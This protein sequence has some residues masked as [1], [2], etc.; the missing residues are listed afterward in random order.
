MAS[1]RWELGLQA[2]VVVTGRGD[3]ISSLV[4]RVASENHQPVVA[5]GRRRDRQRRGR[6]VGRHRC[7]P[8]CSPDGHVESFARDVGIPLNLKAAVC[9]IFTGQVKKLDV[10]EVNGRVF[11]NNS[12]VGFYPHFVRKSEATGHVKRVA[13][14]LAARS[15]VRRYLRLRVKS[16]WTERKYST[17]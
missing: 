12:G 7:C 8:W 9:N 5:A 17:T 16:T 2:H 4:A 14:M 3:D 13:F 11:V 1:G 6:Q 15:V 10:A